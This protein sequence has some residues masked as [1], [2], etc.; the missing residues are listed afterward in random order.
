MFFVFMFSHYFGAK[1]QNVFT[2]ME[3]MSG[4]LALLR[5]C[6]ERRVRI[7]VFTRSVNGIRGHCI[8]FVAA[9]DKMWNLALE[10]VRE[11]WTRKIKRKSVPMEAFKFHFKVV[12][13]VSESS[14]GRR[15]ALC[16]PTRKRHHPC[17]ARPGPS[18]WPL[19]CSAHSW[20]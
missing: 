16:S 7:K 12:R 19:L 14:T 13:A 11:V 18:H 5:D 20:H 10:D 2:R 8:A 17:P 3:Q 4:P 6:M 9:F 1:G 15:G